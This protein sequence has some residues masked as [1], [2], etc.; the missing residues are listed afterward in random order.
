MTEKLNC[1][2][3]QA[4]LYYD[5]QKLFSEKDCLAYQNRLDELFAV[6][7]GLSVE[8]H[9]IIFHTSP[10]DATRDRFVNGRG[11]RSTPLDASLNAYCARRDKF[12]LQ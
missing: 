2:C 9:S 5:L 6:T 10:D 11:D 1:R 12:N 4:K 3:C 7:N 8:D